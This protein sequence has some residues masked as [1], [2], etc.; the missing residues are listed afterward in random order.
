MSPVG[1][2]DGG[3]AG[4]V[5]TACQSFQTA[6]QDSLRDVKFQ[7]R[8]WQRLQANL[9]VG[10]RGVGWGGV[11]SLI[12]GGAQGEAALHPGICSQ[13][14]GHMPTIKTSRSAA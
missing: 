8:A 3:G 2:G 10:Q 5:W 9:S 14:A 13:L 7:R 6:L 12:I 4:C 1:G 11:L